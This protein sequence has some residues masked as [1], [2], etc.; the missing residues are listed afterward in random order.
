MHRSLGGIGKYIN[1]ACEL[2]DCTQ[3]LLNAR[4][5]FSPMLKLR[6]SNGLY[7]HAIGILIKH[8]HNFDWALL[9]HVNDD[10]RIQQILEHQS[11]SRS[12]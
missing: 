12:D 7:R 5:F 9:H 3:V 11:S 2:F 10:I 1:Q 8:V 6:K 4:T